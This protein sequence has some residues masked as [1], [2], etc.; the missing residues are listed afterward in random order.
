MLIF[1]VMRRF[2]SKNQLIRLINVI[3]ARIF[4]DKFT[5][6]VNFYF[7][8]SSSESEMDQNPDS[9]TV[10][11]VDTTEKQPAK[12][13]FPKNLRAYGKLIQAVANMSATSRLFFAFDYDGTLVDTD[14]IIVEFIAEFQPVLKHPFNDYF[15]GTLDGDGWHRV[16]DEIIAVDPI[17]NRQKI[18]D[19]RKKMLAAP[20]IQPELVNLYFTYWGSLGMTA[21]VTNSVLD[22]IKSK[23]LKSKTIARDTNA[24][25]RPKPMPDMYLAAAMLCNTS[26]DTVKIAFEDSKTGIAAA[27]A[28]GYITFNVTEPLTY[29]N[30]L[31]IILN[32]QWAALNG[33][34][35][36]ML[37]AAI[38]DRR[39]FELTPLSVI[40]A[41]DTII[42]VGGPLRS[43][44][45]YIASYRGPALSPIECEIFG[46]K[47]TISFRRVTNASLRV[48][49][50]FDLS[51]KAY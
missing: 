6:P 44:N 21:V 50:S 38:V 15:N 9:E 7:S 33:Y 16:F 41:I 25:L 51:L 36:N 5:M 27:E 49:I 43:S 47:A 19:F 10:V 42:F 14:A 20:E 8:S 26:L 11:D 37:P 32:S 18:D 4:M 13:V 40:D 29:F 23:F 34:S 2:L 17:E 1:V 3:K 48:C 30:V 45:V 28:A 22:L 35:V 31:K 39:L 46:A 24:S 12:R